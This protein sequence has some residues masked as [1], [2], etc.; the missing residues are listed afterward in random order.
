[1]NG[2]HWAI[3]IGLLF[4]LLI[5]V[6]V[7]WYIQY[8]I[9]NILNQFIIN[10]EQFCQEAKY[11][12]YNPYLYPPDI[13]KYYQP[14]AQLMMDICANISVANCT[15]LLPI[16][17]PP[18]FTESLRVEGINPS[19]GQ[20]NMFAYIFW[21]DQYAIIGFTATIFLSEWLLDF[22]YQQ[23]PPTGFFAFFEGT[24]VH[25]GF[26][27]IYMA[28]RDQLVA[29]RAAHPTHKL[30]IVGHSL[31]GA[32]ATLCACDFGTNG[33]K[34]NLVYTFG[35]PRVGNPLFAS[36]C[37]G[38]VKNTM[39]VE[40]TEDI[41]P[42]LPPAGIQNWVYEHVR[43]NIP[44]TVA[45]S[46]QP[47]R[48]NHIQAYLINLPTCPEVGGCSTNQQFV[49]DEGEVIINESCNKLIKD[50]LNEPVKEPTKEPIKESA[51]ELVKEPTKEPVKESLEEVKERVDRIKRRGNRGPSPLTKY[52]AK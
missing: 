47:L 52:I 22:Q 3:L 28:I 8:Y 45:Y 27:S 6:F 37:N 41:V 18:T 16:P 51:K 14:Y 12:V 33:E 43:N 20:N 10:E 23:V 2:R 39:R 29:W 48:N 38:L 32:L 7:W 26:Y 44:F 9:N 49:N 1:M 21:N 40:N 11:I 46:D 25:K 31:G 4:V 19:S 13:R 15:N 35:S 34:D 17:M 5:V 24:L 50:E 42:A 30:T 36:L